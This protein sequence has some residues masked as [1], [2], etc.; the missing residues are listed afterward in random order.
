MSGKMPK[1]LLR[2]SFKRNPGG[3][4]GKIPRG[5]GKYSPPAIDPGAH[6]GKYSPPAQ[7]PRGHQEYSPPD[8]KK[9]PSQRE[10]V[11]YLYSSNELTAEVVEQNVL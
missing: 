6:Q 3:K 5:R 11:S 2:M 10:G 8:P 4:T 9:T 7:G 1:N